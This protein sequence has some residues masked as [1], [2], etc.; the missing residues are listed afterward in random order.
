MCLKTAEQEANSVDPDQMPH[1]VASGL[2]LHCLLG[3]YQHTDAEHSFPY[4]SQKTGFEFLSNLHVSLGDNF[5]G[6]SE[7]HI[8]GKMN[9]SMLGKNF[10]R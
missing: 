5:L 1:F 6:M 9:R 7:L 2:G 8:R 10:S 4:F 3:Q